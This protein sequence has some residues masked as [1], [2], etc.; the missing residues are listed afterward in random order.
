VEIKTW[1]LW[2]KRCRLQPSLICS[3]Q[4]CGDYPQFLPAGHFWR[5]I[6][7]HWLIVILRRDIQIMIIL[8][9]P[10]DIYIPTKSTKNSMSVK[11]MMMLRICLLVKGVAVSMSALTQMNAAYNA[12]DIDSGYILA[13]LI[14]RCTPWNF[15]HEQYR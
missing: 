10:L 12:F 6:F 5:L 3:I 9:Y 1:K 8:C 14:R 2:F 7:C 4:S 15:L 13:Y 11:F